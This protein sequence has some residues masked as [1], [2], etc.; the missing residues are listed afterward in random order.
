MA[1]HVSFSSALPPQ[2]SVYHLTPGPFTDGEESHD[3]HQ[4]FSAMVM[5]RVKTTSSHKE[6]GSH[7]FPSSNKTKWLAFSFCCAE[8][9]TDAFPWYLTWP[10]V[11]WLHFNGGEKSETKKI[12]S[13]FSKYVWERENA[14]QKLFMWVSG[15]AGL[16]SSSYANMS[17]MEGKGDSWNN[18]LSSLVK[19]DTCS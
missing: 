18:Q 16:R 4:Y 8:M 14:K 9:N 12:L 6:P 10:N 11:S 5:L 7:D 13:F 3:V 19:F 17:F 15:P 1:T 2:F